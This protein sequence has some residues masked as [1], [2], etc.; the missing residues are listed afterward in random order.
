MKGWL[1][2]IPAVCI[3]FGMT[4]EDSGIG[5]GERQAEESKWN[6]I[7]IQNRIA[8]D[9]DTL[10]CRW[11]IIVRDSS[12]GLLDATISQNDT[13][14]YYGQSIDIM[15][16]Y[17]SKP[18]YFMADSIYDSI[19]SME[20]QIASNRHSSLFLPTCMNVSNPEIVKC[21]NITFEFVT[22][23]ACVVEDKNIVYIRSRAWALV[24]N[25]TLGVSYTSR[26]SDSSV[27]NTRF[28]QILRSVRVLDQ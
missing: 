10:C 4:C 22:D 13:S 26:A 27:H 9:I 6:Q 25:Y 5:S 28:R 20:S 7:V 14:K 24:G 2:Y 11:S 12:H 1:I 19:Y 16:V 21:D 8:V 15:Y 3:L 23:S 17:I 18:Q